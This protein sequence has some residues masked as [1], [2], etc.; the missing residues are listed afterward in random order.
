MPHSPF[1]RTVH[2]PVDVHSWYE[3]LQDQRAWYRGDDNDDWPEHV[4]SLLD[5]GSNFYVQIEFL[6]KKIAGKVRLF[7]IN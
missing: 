6:D 4:E 3:D 7:F 2:E 1:T 5:I